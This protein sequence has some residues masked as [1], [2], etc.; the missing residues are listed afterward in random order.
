M[1]VE[2]VWTGTSRIRRIEKG[3]ITLGS[4][5]I[6]FQGNSRPTIIRLPRFGN[7]ATYFDNIS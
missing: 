1:F 3:E 4:S 2:T 7:E 6:K 5:S